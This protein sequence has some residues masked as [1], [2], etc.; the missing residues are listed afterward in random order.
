MR[1]ESSWIIKYFVPALAAVAGHAICI[2]LEMMSH[3]SMDPR[4]KATIEHLEAESHQA[5]AH[6]E[7]AK[8]DSNNYVFEETIK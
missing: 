8:K 5:V 1:N 3:I 4:I 2:K 6:I 7:Q